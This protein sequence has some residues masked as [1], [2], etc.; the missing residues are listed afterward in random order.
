MR[1]TRLNLFIE[2]EHA[3]RLDE[4]AIKKAVSKSSLVAAALAAWLGPTS[5]DQR[6]TAM[7]KRLDRLSR[8]YERL[9]RDQNILIETVALYVRYYLTVVTPVPAAHQDAARAQG[10]LRFSQFVEQ[11]GRR[12]QKGRRLLD[13]VQTDS[14]A[15]NTGPEA[16]PGRSEPK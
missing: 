11:L 10:R 13:D 4:L 2:P 9:E 8:Q 12:L 15:D 6:E 16:D 7:A 5:G 14:F 3:R 1:R